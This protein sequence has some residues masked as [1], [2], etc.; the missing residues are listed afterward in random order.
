[1]SNT[2]HCTKLRLS[3]CT[4]SWVDAVKK[5]ADFNY[6]PPSM[7]VFLVFRKI[8]SLKV[9]LPLKGYQNIKFHGSTLTRASFAS[10]SEV[11]TSAV[12][13][14]LQLQ[15][16][17][18]YSRGHLQWYL[19]LFVEI[20]LQRLWPPNPGCKDMTFLTNLKKSNNIGSKIDGGQTDRRWSH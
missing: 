10:T 15:H 13:E 9:I 1:M 8:V 6:E 19:S 7:F 17:K 18:L 11:W 5:N 2:F 4:D 20:N 16:K 14:W 12:L 3:K